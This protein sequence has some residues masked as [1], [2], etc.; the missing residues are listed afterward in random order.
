[1]ARIQRKRVQKRDRQFVFGDELSSDEPTTEGAQ[2]D[3]GPHHVWLNALFGSSRPR[4][5]IFGGYEVATFASRKNP[6]GIARLSF[7][8]KLI[9]RSPLCDSWST[10][11]RSV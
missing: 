11:P 8:T 5:C 3:S 4:K 9:G 1:M 7:H 6:A 10:G 2:H